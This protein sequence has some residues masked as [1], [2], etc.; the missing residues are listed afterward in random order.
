MYLLYLLNT[1]LPILAFPLIQR[2][3]PL[4]LCRI[5]LLHNSSNKLEEELLLVLGQGLRIWTVHLDY[6]SYVGEDWLLGRVGLQLDVVGRQQDRARWG[7]QFYGRD[8]TLQFVLDLFVQALELALLTLQYLAQLLYQL[9][10]VWLFVVFAA[11][12][13]VRYLSDKPKVKSYH[14]ILILEHRK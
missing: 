14:I 6:Y 8:N 12:D 1:L 4:H 5:V 10:L 3:N 11:C 9:C 13:F 7:G 2:L